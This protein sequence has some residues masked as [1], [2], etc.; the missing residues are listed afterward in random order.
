MAPCG[1]PWVIGSASDSVDPI[2]TVRERPDNILNQFNVADDA[3][4]AELL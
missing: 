3:P 1:T 4:I 2:P